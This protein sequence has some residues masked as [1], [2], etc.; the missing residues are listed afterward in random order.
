M[1]ANSSGETAPALAANATPPK[2]P[3][4][5]TLGICSAM[6][7]LPYRRA[8]RPARFPKL[9]KFPRSAEGVSW[10]FAVLWLS[11]VFPQRHKPNICLSSPC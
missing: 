6:F 11:G 7:F 9:A 10:H 3:R 5:P 8:M 2:K 4:R 1:G